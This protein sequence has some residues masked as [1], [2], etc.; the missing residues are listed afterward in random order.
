MVKHHAREDMT[1]KDVDKTDDEWR[2]VHEKKVVDERRPLRDRDYVISAGLET[3]LKR[4]RVGRE[5]Y[6]E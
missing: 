3:V 6:F 2:Q 4:D 1:I 5:G